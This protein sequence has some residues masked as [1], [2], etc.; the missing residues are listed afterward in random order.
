MNVFYEEEGTSRSAR[1]SPTTPPR[2]RSRRR[3][4]S[5]RRSRRRRAAALR[6]PAGSANSRPR[7]SKL[8]DDIDVDFLWQCCGEEEFAF[9]A[10]AREYF[11][12]APV[13]VEAAA[14]LLKLHGAPMYF[15]KKG[16]GRYKAAPEEALKAALASVERKR[17]EAE[18]RQ[19]TWGS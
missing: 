17:R 9:D 3:T 10:L 12:R 14:L 16:K 4:A 19:R 13:A 6:R 5:A 2:C 8:A 7:R 18:Q 11:G 1:S 15:Y